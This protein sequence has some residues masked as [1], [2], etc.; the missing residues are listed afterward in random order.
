MIPKHALTTPISGVF[1]LAL[2]LPM[3]LFPGL[4]AH[5]APMQFTSPFP[6][7]NQTNQTPNNQTPAYGTASTNLGNGET[8]E[9]LTGPQNTF[10]RRDTLTGDWDDF[11]NQLLY[12]G[13]AITP[14][15][16]GEVFGNWGGAK[17]GVI[18]DG[19]FNV[20]LDIDLERITGGFWK[21]AVLHANAMDIY[22]SSLSGKYVGDFSNTSNLAGPNS[23]RL[24]ELWLDQGFWDKRASLRV[25][26]MAADT[27]FFTSN[28]SSLFL[29]G[30]F[31]AFT[32][33]G[34][35]FTNAPVYPLAA[36]G[37]RLFVQ[38]TSKFYMRFRRLRD[39]R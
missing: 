23:I 26:M 8:V 29:N 7:T 34:A 17:Q 24:Q 36:P 14:V 12:R 10:W 30:T 33:I 16:Q 35:N 5:G 39:E 15:W 4:A 27:E 18:S 32:L 25:G 9:G 1:A 37:V 22:G 31:G 28:S 6:T 11:R 38:P 13:I 19:L 3:A 21:D 2:A 20:A